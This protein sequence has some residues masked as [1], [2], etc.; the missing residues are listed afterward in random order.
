MSQDDQF[1]FIIYFPSLHYFEFKYW[2]KGVL[3][4]LSSSYRYF[5]SIKMHN[6][7]FQCLENVN[8]EFTLKTSC[9][10][11]PILIDES[12]IGENHFQ[13]GEKVQ[14]NLYVSTSTSTRVYY[15]FMLLKLWVYW[16]N[17][18]NRKT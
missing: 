12:K 10:L 16:F 2:R 4:K 5:Q 8:L 9:A 15:Y 1:G 18:K 11:S 17:G 3:C 13:N 7:H 14:K 6:K